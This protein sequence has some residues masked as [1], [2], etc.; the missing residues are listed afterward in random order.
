MSTRCQEKR[1]NFAQTHFLESTNQKTNV[2][3]KVLKSKQP[4][5]VFEGL[6][7][8]TQDVVRTLSGKRRHI[9]KAKKSL[10][11][12]LDITVE[13]NYPTHSVLTPAKFDLRFRLSRGCSPSG[14]SYFVV[15]DKYA[16]L[17]S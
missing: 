6:S 12:G 11:G 4:T 10:H 2:N 3:T 15:R 14:R 9:A 7:R 1:T 17:S 8:G 16:V 5:D 13:H